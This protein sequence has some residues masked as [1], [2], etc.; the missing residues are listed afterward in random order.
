MCAFGGLA[1]QV[2]VR[3]LEGKL[4]RSMNAGASLK[5]RLDRGAAPGTTADLQP[6]PPQNL[7]S[8]VNTGKPVVE[9]YD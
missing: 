9:L 4:R 5:L 6:P 7:P 2:V 1:S 8:A 3:D